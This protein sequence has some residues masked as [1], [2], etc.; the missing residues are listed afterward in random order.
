MAGGAIGGAISGAA[1]GAIVYGPVGAVVGAVVGAAIGAGAGAAGKDELEA[2]GD[3]KRHRAERQ[4][5]GGMIYQD[6]MNAIQ[7]GIDQEDVALQT[8]RTGQSVGGLLMGIAAMNQ[9]GFLA[10]HPWSWPPSETAREALTILAGFGTQP[11]LDFNWDRL[12]S[13][14]ELVASWHSTS[15]LDI[16]QIAVNAEALMAAFVNKRGSTVL[17]GYDEQLST[18]LRGAAGRLTRET[19]IPSSRAREAAGQDLFVVGGSTDSLTEDQLQRLLQRLAKVDR[20]RDLQ[21]LRIESDFGATVTV[22]HLTV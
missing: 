4:K 6:L 16:D 5:L 9:S 17:I 8:V 21:I 22:G 1:L 15:H 3:R 13:T 18:G 2:M 11:V 12:N 14:A 19:L 20:D 7:T 10:D